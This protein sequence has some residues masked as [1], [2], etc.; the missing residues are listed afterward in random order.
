[1][2]LCAGIMVKNTRWK[3]YEGQLFGVSIIK[4]RNIP[5][6]EVKIKF[7]KNIV[8]ISGTTVI[9]YAKDISQDIDKPIIIMKHKPVGS[10]ECYKIVF[11]EGGYLGC[12]SIIRE[13]QKKIISISQNE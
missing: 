1:V 2:N 13:K 12:E 5:A 7:G 6:H 11:P 8:G 10:E 3:L 9:R 4:G